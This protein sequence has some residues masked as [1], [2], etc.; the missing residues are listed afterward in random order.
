MLL[1]ALLPAIGQADLRASDYVTSK[2]WDTGFPLGVTMKY[3][4]NRRLREDLETKLNALAAAGR[5]NPASIIAPTSLYD[6]TEKLTAGYGMAKFGFDGGQVV[7]G[8]RVEHMKQKIAGFTQAGTTVTPLVVEN[9]YTD[10]FPSVNAKVELGQ[11]MV[12]RGA[13]QRGVARP[14]FGAI[15]TGASINDTSTPGT[16]SGGNPRLKPEYT[17][18]ADVSSNTTC[19]ATASCRWAASIATWTTCSTTRGPRWLTIPMTPAGLIARAM[20]LSRP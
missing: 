8:A 12:L 1:S 18:G 11:D 2:V 3:L 15:R 14:S 7:F 5:Y 6:I 19:P 4:D 13:V 9:D 20:T 17:W 16:V 10:I